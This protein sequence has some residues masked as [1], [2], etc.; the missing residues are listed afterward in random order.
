MIIRTSVRQNPAYV[1]KKYPQGC[2]LF[3]LR[4]GIFVKDF[5]IIMSGHQFIPNISSTKV[6]EKSDFNIKNDSAGSVLKT[7]SQYLVLLLF[8]LVPIFFIPGLWASLGFDKALLTLGIASL[9]VVLSCFMF[10]TKTRITTV[11]PISLGLFWLVVLGAFISG[12]SSGDT[13]DALRGSVFEIH[14]VSFLAVLGIAMSVPLVFQGSKVMTIKTIG[15]FFI[16][17]SL[18]LVYSLLRIIFGADFLS[19]GSFST[20]TLSPVGSFNDIA[21][22]SGLLIVSSLITLILLPLRL[23]LQLILSF[24]VIIALTLLSVV[25]FVSIWVVIGFFGLLILIF[26]LTRDTL[27]VD[28]ESRQA[29]RSRLLIAITTIVCVASAIF[30]VAGDYAENKINSFANVEYAEVVPSIEGTLG[31]ARGV[32]EEGALLGIGPNRFVDAWRLYKDPSINETIFWDTDF[33]AGSGFVTTLFINL[34]LLGGVLF[35]AFNLWFLYLGFR[36]L[37]KSTEKDSYW[38]YV[39]AVSFASACFVWGMAYVYEPSAAILLI[40]ALF[41]GMTFVS[42]GVLLPK[43]VYTIPLVVNRKRGFFLMALVI[44]V[45]ALAVMM[46]VAVGKQYVAESSFAKSQVT[47]ESVAEFEEVASNSFSLYPDDR[48]VNVR[49]QIKLADLNSLINNPSPTEEDHQIFLNTVEQVQMFAD[50]ALSQDETNPDNHAILAGVYSRLAIAGINGAKERAFDSLE[51]AQEF[52]PM[53]PGYSLLAAQM[54]AG[55]GDLPLAREE[56]AK[57]LQLKPNFTEALFLS[58]Q[59]DISEGKTDSAIDTTRSIITLEPQN[60][61][62]YFQLGMLQSSK[63]NFLGAIASLEAAVNLDP[64]YANARYLLALAYL[65]VERPE[66]ALRQLESVVYTNP[67]NLQ[68]QSLIAQ[69][70]SGEEVSVPDLGFDTP[71]SEVSPTEGDVDSDVSRRSDDTDLISPVN[72]VS[73]VEVDENEENATDQINETEEEDV[74]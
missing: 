8:T 23:W 39:S 43:M 74:E 37:I 9:V 41:T 55:S 26:L 60:P 33:H 15:L 61:T 73:G 51:K 19:F 62:R 46:L 72:T 58:A 12:V 13:L 57:S 14:T 38:N 49:A 56:I 52:D 50:Q 7:I 63:S 24:V 21:I 27:F 36:I 32:Y 66:D 5:I 2:F 30:I 42:A 40:G 59:I 44:I 20:V 1:Y 34:G 69:I 31:I 47:A 67:D 65:S 48:F 28:Q 4:L 3:V 54:A 10:L 71:V 22:L 68:L 6:E 29:G 53:N 16:S 18:L 64:Q 70:E 17:S 35:L 45:T 11:L 25:N